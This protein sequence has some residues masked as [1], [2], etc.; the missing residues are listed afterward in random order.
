M[1]LV[2]NR[3][4][5]EAATNAEYVAARLKEASPHAWRA[6]WDAPGIAVYDSGAEKGRMQTYRLVA[7]GVV[8]GRLFRNDYTSVT[9]DLDASE[10]A[11]CLNTKG[12]HL[13]DNYWGRYV[14][15]LNK[16]PGDTYYVMRDPSGA[17]PCFYTS[18]R[19]VEIYFSDMQDVAS[20]EFLRFSVNWDYIRTNFLLPQYQKTHTGLDEVGEVLPAECIEAK[21]FGRNRRL[22]WDPWKI[23]ES[24]IVE[25]PEAAAELIRTTVKGTIG[26]LAGCYDRVL[27]NLGGLD[28]SIVLACLAAAPKRPEITSL[29]FYTK[30][31]RGEERYYSRQVAQRAGTSLIEIELQHER[32]DLKKV[33][34][35]NATT[36]PQGFFD[37]INLT[38]DKLEYAKDKNV[39]AL[40]YGVGGDNVFYQMPFNLGALDYVRCHGFRGNALKVA[41][42]A[43]RYGRKSIFQT[44]H[45][46]CQE[47]VRPAPCY[48][49]IYNLIYSDQQLPLLK[50]EFVNAGAL[51]HFLHPHLIPADDRLKGKYVHI[52]ASAMFSIEYYDHWDT[53]YCA[54]Q[55]FAFLAQPIVEACLRIPVWVL[56][57]G[58]IDRALARE[59]FQDDLPSEVVRRVSKSTPVAYYNDLYDNQL[60]LL[61]S[62]L[63][64]GIL[65]REGILQRDKLEAALGNEDL[66]LRV[67][68]HDILSYFAT[69]AWLAKWRGRQILQPSKIEIAV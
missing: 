32:A 19:G 57:R 23:S 56:T 21:S 54:E 9:N 50:Q 4:D 33:F 15:F 24:N 40:F 38:G 42:D 29:N 39:Q 27:H 49:Y 44:S 22:L 47:F 10:S 68:Q 69:E 18:F 16:P 41:M 43:S 53:D 35:S 59:A 37:C 12:Q 63:L 3:S 60:D 28:S 25:D 5:H 8:L 55:I 14:A 46:M 58:G 31:P 20:F 34:R 26:A 6:S 7:G 48:D 52:L 11:A 61:R 62:T 65:V 67:N 51:E 1:T 2:W 66:S 45:D 64:D 13:I 36:N 30:C 17:F